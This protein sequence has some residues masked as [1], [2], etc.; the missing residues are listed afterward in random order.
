[1]SEEKDMAAHENRSAVQVSI[2]DEAAARRLMDLANDHLDKRPEAI[3]HF[4]ESRTCCQKVILTEPNRVDGQAQQLVEVIIEEKPGRPPVLD[5]LLINGPHKPV[6]NF[7]VQRDT[8]TVFDQT[9]TE[10]TEALRR[11]E[12][13]IPLYRPDVPYGFVQDGLVLGFLWSIIETVKGEA[14][15]TL[16]GTG[17]QFVAPGQSMPAGLS[18][19]DGDYHRYMQS[20]WELLE[21]GQIVNLQRQ[22]GRAED[23]TLVL[24]EGHPH[25]EVTA[26]GEP[27]SPRF[28]RRYDLWLP[29]DSSPEGPATKETAATWV[30]AVKSPGRARAMNVGSRLFLNGIF[31]ES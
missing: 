31:T 22:N 26:S 10:L 21:A 9:D 18:L 2:N 29:C 6:Q 23:I 5:L 24:D 11:L 20:F 16:Q 14:G 25:V 8:I 12:T 4:H 30:E 7:E 28:G 17:F 1:V 15:E 13:G 19:V 3:S 27:Q